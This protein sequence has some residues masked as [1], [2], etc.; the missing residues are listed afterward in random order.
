MPKFTI[1][2]PKKLFKP[3]P[4]LSI[5]ECLEILPNLSQY[6]YDDYADG[7]NRREFLADRLSNID[8]IWLGIEGESAS[9]FS[10]VYLSNEQVYEV[11][12]D[13]FAISSDWH[14]AL[15]YLS[16]LSQRLKQPILF[17]N[18]QKVGSDFD[19]F[20]LMENNLQRLFEVARTEEQTLVYLKR[21]VV[22]GK[23]MS[24]KLMYLGKPIISEYEKLVLAAQY[25][26]AHVYEQSFHLNPGNKTIYGNYTY[27][28]DLDAILPLRPFVEHQNQGVLVGHPLTHWVLSFAYNEGDK[29]HPQYETKDTFPYDLAINCLL[30]YPHEQLDENFIILQALKREQLDAIVARLREEHA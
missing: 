6:S 28:E 9:G 24:N 14:L 11:Y 13:Y 2:N 30:D 1:K 4:V 17:E 5:Q 16:A 10:L 18:G 29:H 21:P 23:Q 12:V 3:Q 20:S 25:P 19:Y 8:N 7:F 22:F 26:T 15:S 27:G